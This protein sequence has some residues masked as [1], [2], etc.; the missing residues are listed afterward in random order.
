M[1]SPMSF[2]ER[3]KAIKELGLNKNLCYSDHELIVML[4]EKRANKANFDP[5]FRTGSIVEEPPDE[6]RRREFYEE[7][8]GEILSVFNA[9]ISRDEHHP[10]PS[11]IVDYAA[12]IV[13]ELAQRAGEKGCL[14]S[15]DPEFG[16]RS[17]ID[18]F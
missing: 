18:E 11:F 12:C 8:A 13:S 16:G 10:S 15:G 7:H 17:S 9:L 2:Q 4:A 6:K 1:N 5:K 14:K 3:I